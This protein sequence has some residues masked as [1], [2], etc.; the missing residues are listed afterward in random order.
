[1][2]TITFVLPHVRKQ[3]N[4]MIARYDPSIGTFTVP[5][6]GEGLYYFST[7]VLVDA[8]EWA[9]FNI[10]VNGVNL[11]TVYKWLLWLQALDHDGWPTELFEFGLSY[12]IELIENKN[13]FGHEGSKLQYFWIG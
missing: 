7:Y 12:S 5:P 3:S 9:H 8:G 2:A 4:H 6:G 11:C 1:M 10:R 13:Y